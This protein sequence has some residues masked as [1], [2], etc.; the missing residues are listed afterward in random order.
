MKI[1][2]ITFLLGVIAG[3]C[4]WL[5]WVFQIDIA[6]HILAVCACVLLGISET[7]RD[8]NRDRNRDR[9]TLND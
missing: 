6:K 1:D 5:A 4:T 7:S 3:V 8:R 2:R 9:H